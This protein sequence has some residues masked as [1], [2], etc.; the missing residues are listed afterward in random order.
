M[1][2]FASAT[3]RFTPATA[4][5]AKPDYSCW[6]GSKESL[7]GDVA[8]LG[9]GAY[10]KLDD[11]SRKG[12]QSNPYRTPMAQKAAASGTAGG[13]G[14]GRLGGVAPVGGVAAIN[15]S[16]NQNARPAMPMAKQT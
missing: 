5:A 14:T 10:I 8:R 15:Q 1:Q 4:P 3:A 12:W 6:D 9:P 11:W 16:I 7:K 2:A 13:G